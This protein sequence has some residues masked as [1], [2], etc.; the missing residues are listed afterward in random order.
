MSGFQDKHMR[1]MYPP[2]GREKWIMNNWIITVKTDL[3]AS[4]KYLESSKNPDDCWMVQP[5]KHLYW[6]CNQQ[7]TPELLSDWQIGLLLW[8][9]MVL[10]THFS[11]FECTLIQTPWKRDP[12]IASMIEIAQQQP[13][14][15]G[16]LP[17]CGH[18]LNTCWPVKEGHLKIHHHLFWSQ[19]AIFHT[20]GAFD[21]VTKGCSYL[22]PSHCV[23]KPPVLVWGASVL[24]QELKSTCHWW[25]SS[26]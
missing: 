18:V 15:T 21:F 3:V 1:K 13:Y 25:Q 12:A 11:Q 26:H 10:D 19:H 14:H 17:L 6:F 24:S 20:V 22:F 7:T 8:K 2:L 5:E 9:V 4:S 16:S 23:T